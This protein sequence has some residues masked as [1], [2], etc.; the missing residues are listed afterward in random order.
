LLPPELPDLKLSGDEA[1]R[2]LALQGPPPPD[3]ASDDDLRRLLAGTPPDILTGRAWLAGSKPELRARIAAM[4]QPVFPVQGRDL[5]S[6]GVQPG[7]EMGRM[8]RQLRQDWLDSG[9][10]A[11]APALLD[12]L[13]P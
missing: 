2:L 12:K 7:P 9:C 6:L 8:L 1:E 3:D 5:L 4:P 10:V 11:N 13:R